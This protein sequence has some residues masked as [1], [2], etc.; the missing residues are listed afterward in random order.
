MAN[1]LRIMKPADLKIAQKERIIIYGR[2]GIGKTR[3]A[4]S[5]PPR[6]GKVVYFA[7]DDNSEFLSSIDPSKRDRVIVVKPEGDDPSALF[8]QFAMTDWKAID[9]EIGTVVVDTYTKIALDAIRHSA[10]TGAVTAEKHFVVGDPAKGGVVLPNR[11][12]YM[13]IDSLSRGFLTMLFTKQKDMHI[14]LLCHE[15]VKIVENVHAVG[16]PAHPGRAMTEYLP[17]QANTVIRLIREQLLVPGA[18]APE[19]VVIAIGENDGKFIAKVRTS[20]EG[21][22]NPLARVVLD[23]NPLNYWTKYD[24]LFNATDSQEVK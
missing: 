14:I 15:D 17:A 1:R 22:A 6:Y 5:L 24:A 12:D 16:G 18:D 9:P 8:M 19:D 11:G 4:L 21:S 10:M 3:M 2:A 23:R 13:A 20:D 7:A